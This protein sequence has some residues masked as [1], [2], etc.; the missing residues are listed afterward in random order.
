MLGYCSGDYVFRV[1][2][3]TVGG[4]RSPSN[5]SRRC[6]KLPADWWRAP[7]VTGGMT[8]FCVYS[9]VE[10]MCCVYEI[11]VLYVHPTE[12]PETDLYL[13]LLFRQVL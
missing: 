4:S 11:K 3:A 5:L 10:L 13:V 6:G 7:A 12:H 8:Q 2:W 1:L 9:P